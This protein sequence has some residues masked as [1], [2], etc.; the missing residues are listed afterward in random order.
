[1]KEKDFFYRSMFQICSSLLKKG[2]MLNSPDQLQFWQIAQP[3]SFH[4]YSSRSR[5]QVS[6]HIYL[7]LFIY[8]GLFAC[9]Q[10]SFHVYR[11]LFTY[12]GLGLVSTHDD[13]YSCL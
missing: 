13:D 7:P 6:F 9:I 10:V 3:L 12:I 2:G 1:M 4:V 8:T 5:I 11:S